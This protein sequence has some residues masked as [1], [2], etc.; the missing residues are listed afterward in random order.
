MLARA[1][2]ASPGVSGTFPN[3]ELAVYLA[4]CRRGFKDGQVVGHRLDDL[5]G[6]G[7]VVESLGEQFGPALQ[8]FIM[9]VPVFGNL[10]DRCETTGV[11]WLVPER[12]SLVEGRVV[13]VT[14]IRG[15]NGIVAYP[16]S[17]SS[18]PF[19]CFVKNT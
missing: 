2:A 10:I 11:P 19:K 17:S 9:I 16:Q 7:A 14:E 6:E 5:I 1:V 3:P 8:R 13:A 18:L 4:H 15:S 12:L